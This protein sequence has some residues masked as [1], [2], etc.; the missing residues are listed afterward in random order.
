VSGRRYITQRQELPRWVDHPPAAGM[1]DRG[2]GPG[3]LLRGLH[4]DHC[5]QVLA[6]PGHRAQELRQVS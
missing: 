1:A 5:G 2:S 3:R 4:R 6:V